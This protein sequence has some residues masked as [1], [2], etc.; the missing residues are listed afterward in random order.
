M[1]TAERYHSIRVESIVIEHMETDMLVG[2]E[3]G[4]DMAGDGHGLVARFGELMSDGDLDGLA[5]LY[6]PTAKV[7]LFYRVASGRDEI[8]E[9]LAGSLA[10]H[11]RYRVMSVDQFQDA[12]D[13]VM[14]DAT[15]ETALGPLQTTH[16]VVLDSDGLI[17]RHVPGIR[18][19][20]GM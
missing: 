3:E 17:T 1:F 10:S 8:R 4:R 15:V 6:A 13:V 12:G 7:V 5:G 11:E 9:L 14:W 19:Y 20:W 18:G 16:V 2:V